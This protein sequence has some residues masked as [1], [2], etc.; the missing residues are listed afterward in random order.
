MFLHVTVE[1]GIATVIAVTRL[2][3]YAINDDKRWDRFRNLCLF[4]VFLALAIAAAASW[5]LLGDGGLQV[6]LNDFGRAS[7]AATR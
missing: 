5:W 4:I 3:A 6:L 1:V 7:I 2:I